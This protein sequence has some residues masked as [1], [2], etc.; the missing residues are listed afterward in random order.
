MSFVTRTAKKSP[1]LI[2]IGLLIALVSTFVFASRWESVTAFARQSL[3]ASFLGS[4]TIKENSQT[5][6]TALTPKTVNN[7]ALAPLV[8]TYNIPGDYT[9][10]AAAIADLN[11]QGIGGA[12][13]LN[14]VAGNPQTSPAGG[15]VVGGTGS[16]V[17]TTTSITN[18]VTI[19]GNGNTITAPTTH[20]VGA[21]NDAIFKLIGA[22]WITVSG[23]NMQ[24]NAA[25]T[26][27]A[28]ASNNMTE[29][30]VAL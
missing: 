5:E 18:T 14:L 25:N 7:E 29:F 4:Q 11:T 6:S 15:Y 1:R 21:L 10:L 9:D 12:V 30:G 26:T 24:E 8:G 16:L 2:V 19:Q 27:T 22:D 17:L 28:A 13:T 23:F 3:S 20:T